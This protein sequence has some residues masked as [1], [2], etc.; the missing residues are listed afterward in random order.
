MAYKKLKAYKYTEEE[1]RKIWSLEYCEKI[2]KTF[3]NIEVQFYSSMFDHCFFE[4]VNRREKDK[5]ILSLNRLEKIYWIKDALLDTSSL[6]KKGWNRNTK[7]YT[8][9]SRVN[10]VKD[11]YIVVIKLLNSNK[12]RFIT[13]YEVN[14]EENLEKIKNSPDWK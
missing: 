7:S 9:S 3:D 2:I 6:L 13:A 12:A 5:S 11:N 14:N 10:L 1:L 4:S 8:D